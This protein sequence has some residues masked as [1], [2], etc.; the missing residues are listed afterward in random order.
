MESG[1]GKPTES[2]PYALRIAKIIDLNNKRDREK[3]LKRQLHG[4]RNSIPQMNYNAWARQYDPKF[5][6]KL[7]VWHA[8]YRPP[9]WEKEMYHADGGGFSKSEILLMNILFASQPECSKHQKDWMS[10]S[11]LAR[12]LGIDKSAV[13]RRVRRLALCGIVV[14]LGT[15][16]NLNLAIAPDR[17][18]VKTLH[19]MRKAENARK[20][21]GKTW[22]PPWSSA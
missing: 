14:N 7:M 2:T 10:I 3:A 8:S 18:I 12:L 21:R 6:M 13:S 4:K 22:S 15:P 16:R 11:R 19:E 9:D 17:W 5:L 1:P 20:N